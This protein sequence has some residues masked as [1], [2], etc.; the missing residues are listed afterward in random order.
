MGQVPKE[1][2]PVSAV[3]LTADELQ[4]LQI[5]RNVPGGS[6][7]YFTHREMQDTCRLL[8]SKGLATAVK[9]RLPGV[10]AYMISARGAE[11]VAARSVH[12]A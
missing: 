10:T 3:E 12:L 8:V 2:R 4:L 7:A 11:E 6:G 9:V 1:D 5:M